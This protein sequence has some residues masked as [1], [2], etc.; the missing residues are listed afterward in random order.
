MVFMLKCSSW[1]NTL[2]LNFSYSLDKWM[3]APDFELSVLRITWEC[4][5]L[6][7]LLLALVLEIQ[8]MCS[9]TDISAYK[10]CNLSSSS[11]NIYAVLTVCKL[12]SEVAMGIYMAQRNHPIVFSFPFQS[13]VV[14]LRLWKNIYVE[15]LYLPITNLI[16]LE[17]WKQPFCFLL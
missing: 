15:K 16:S 9:C 7:T 6:S 5:H 14:F 2:Q 8:A 17:N 3:R 11:T 10:M 1:T 4:G 13:Y 12:V